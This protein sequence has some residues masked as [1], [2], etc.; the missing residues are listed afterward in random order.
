MAGRRS[1]QFDS[2][3]LARK[4]VKEA[5]KTYIEKT[6]NLTQLARKLKI[7]RTMIWSLCYDPRAY[8]RTME[9]LD[10]LAKEVL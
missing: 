6:S 8:R 1:Q 2:F 10:R 5:T 4:R 9:H 3:A 7:D